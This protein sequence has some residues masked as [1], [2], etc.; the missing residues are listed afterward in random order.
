MEI[1]LWQIVGNAAFDDEFYQAMAEASQTDLPAEW[2]NGNS[3][4][5]ETSNVQALCLPS[6]CMTTDQDEQP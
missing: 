6:L 3:M 4:G 5:G 1:E 2:R